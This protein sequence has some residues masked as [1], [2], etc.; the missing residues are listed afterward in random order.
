MIG[1]PRAF[2]RYIICRV[3]EDLKFDPT[4]SNASVQYVLLHA[5]FGLVFLLGTVERSIKS[6]SQVY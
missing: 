3:W 2:Q 6:T 4:W 5:V 1:L